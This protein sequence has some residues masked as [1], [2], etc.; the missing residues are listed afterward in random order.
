M[1]RT[2]VVRVM[3]DVSVMKVTPRIAG[4]MDRKGDVEGRS[5][6]HGGRR[7]IEKKRPSQARRYVMGRTMTVI[8]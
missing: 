2:V 1:M 3:K 8:A 5:V 4:V 6:D 7:V